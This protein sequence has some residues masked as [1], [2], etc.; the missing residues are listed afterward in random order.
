ML[1][2]GTWWFN[3]AQGIFNDI[4]RSYGQK[5][6]QQNRRLGFMPYPKAPGAQAGLTLTDKMS[7]LGFI[8]ANIADYKKDLAKD[9]LQF[10]NTDESL[11][12]FTRLTSTVKALNYSV[13]QAD[14]D[15]M[16]P[17]GKSVYNIWKISDVV[18]EIS[19]NPLFAENMQ[20]FTDRSNVWRSGS[21]D[22]YPSTALFNSS[23]K[24]AA[25]YFQ[26]MR[27]RMSSSSWADLYGSRYF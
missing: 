23:S 3:E 21:A 4:S 8:N 14:L 7:S 18:Y 1:I 16:T 15:Q 10:V 11:E 19:A 22:I 12:E 13:E 17:F 5:Y 2:E 6:S 20:A 27:D 26:G 24:T 25:A 9:F